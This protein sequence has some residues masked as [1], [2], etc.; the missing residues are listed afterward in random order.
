EGTGPSRAARARRPGGRRGPQRPGARGTA[1]GRSGRAA[2][3]GPRPGRRTARARPAR[4]LPLPRRFRRRP[5][6]RSAERLVRSG[7]RRGAVRPRRL[8]RAA[9]GRSAGLGRDAR[10]RAEG[11]RRLQKITTMREAFAT[12]LGLVTL[13]D[14]MADGVDFVKNARAQDHLRATLFAPETVRVIASGGAALVPGRARG[15]TL[16]G[17]LALLAAELGVPHARSSAAGGLLCL[18][19]V[20]EDTYRL[21][22][23]LTQL[24]RAGWLDGVRGV[25]LGSWESCEGPDQVRALL[26]DRL[27]G[28]GAPVAEDFGF[29]HCEGALTIP[30]GVAAELDA[31]DGT[32]TLEAPALR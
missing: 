18:E 10:G 4:E 32:L 8:R 19:D 12:R 1:P 26:A 27:G 23:Y 7:R 15:V 29:G 21:D 30:F 16:G 14:T 20:G 5:G 2:R 6:R 13:Q 31:E 9:D 3:L 25:L 17:C 24:L 28:L 11:V 22:R